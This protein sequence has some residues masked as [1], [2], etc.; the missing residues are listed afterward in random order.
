MV[1]DGVRFQTAL[2]DPEHFL[3]F[4]MILIGCLSADLQQLLVGIFFIFVIINNKILFNIF[5]Y[6]AIVK[7]EKNKAQYGFRGL[8]APGDPTENAAPV[9]PAFS[10]CG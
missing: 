4:L 8:I 10:R 2:D 9:C 7:L 3:H 5:W 6:F 1:V